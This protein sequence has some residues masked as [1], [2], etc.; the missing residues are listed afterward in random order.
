MGGMS[1]IHMRMPTFNTWN[2]LN[3][4]A[5]VEG[6]SKGPNMILFGNSVTEALD[7][8]RES[9]AP[10]I[11]SHATD[12]SLNGSMAWVLDKIDKAISE[13]GL[14]V[15]ADIIGFDTFSNDL[16]AL[17]QFGT[18]PP[19]VLM[20]LGGIKPGQLWPAETVYYNDNDGDDSNDVVFWE[21][22]RRLTSVED[23]EALVNGFANKTL[24][25]GKDS[26]SISLRVWCNIVAP[27]ATKLALT[28]PFIF[29][30]NDGGISVN[31]ANQVLVE[32]RTYAC[33]SRLIG[34]W[35]REEQ[36]LGMKDALFRATIAPARWM[37]L[38]K[39]GRLQE[40]C[41]ADIVIFDQ[42]KI[43]DRARAED[44]MLELKPLGFSKVIVN[45]QVVVDN[46]ELTG[47][48]PGRLIRRTW[49]IPGNTKDVISLYNKLF[50]R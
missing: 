32:P 29:M 40:G 17:T 44:G 34:H 22:Y 18:I 2:V 13:D 10:M 47:K 45:G 38:S 43:I 33:F 23:A 24:K 46:G 9:G 3:P 28:K 6:S 21:A 48:T 36:A 50:T 30:G 25:V 11:I 15:A 27:A 35:S 1:A 26:T 8:C 4:W 5:P 39:K 7:V 37:G 49:K 19:G 14:P 31:K 16:L 42:N 20:T 12:V 41:D